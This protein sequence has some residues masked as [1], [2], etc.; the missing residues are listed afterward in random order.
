[1]A[2]NKSKLLIFGILVII[3]CLL[4]GCA[5]QVDQG[6]LSG[7]SSHQTINWQNSLEEAVKVASIEKKPIMI[8]FYGVSSK[9]IDERLFSDPEIIKLSQRFVC[10]KVG[11]EWAEL[12]KQYKVIEFPTIVF[13]DRLGRE[14][15]RIVGYK[16]KPSFIS[17]LNDA[18]ATV[19]VEYDVNV[20]QGR[21]P[22]AEVICKFNN[23]RFESLTVY[24]R[25]RHDDIDILS[26]QGSD[27][28]PAIKKV[29]SATWEIRFGSRSKRDLSIK[30]KV[31]LNVLSTMDFEPAYISY[32]GGRY[33]ILD[34]H[35][36]FLDSPDIIATEKVT[37]NLKLPDG[38]SAL[39]P[40]EDVGNFS[41]IADRIEEVVDAVFCIGNFRYSKRQ[42]NDKEIY[43][44]FCGPEGYNFD[45]NSKG[46]LALH[47]FRDYI[48]RFGDYPF[49]KYLAIF[50]HRTPDGKYI[51]GTAHGL[52]FAGPVEMSN[53]NMLQFMA[54]EIFH[55]W[56]GGI[57]LQRSEYEVWFKEGFTQYYGYLTPYRVGF[58]DKSSFVQFLKRDYDEYIRKHESG[59]D[60]AL[61]RVKEGLARQE[62]YRQG[63]SNNLWMMYNKGAL[64]ASLLDDE[65]KEKT[66]GQRSIDDLMR[67]MFTE[68]KDKRY[69][70]DDILNA[71]NKITGH[72]FT[73]FFVDFIY[74]K[75]KLPPTKKL[76]NYDL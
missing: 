67:Y 4:T 14:Y 50:A 32:L 6:A 69:S 5:I 15:T 43:V 8:V 37:V 18:S 54:H 23:V 20:I 26:C 65:I 27:E 25:E 63:R 61:T 71:V 68:F 47:I 3:S 29:Q 7:A 13:T 28:R 46:D 57:I 40:W 1:M 38:W 70:T 56:N 72:D 34:G 73:K 30:Y 41:Y 35:A 2:I 58:Y 75:A 19:Q 16:S 60:M 66:N 49:K 52:G 45:L 48:S 9:R 64:V 74:G 31:G 59:E 44:V 39:T 22:Q 76:E 51:H 36:L 33:G 55:V 21:E 17:L 10:L 11:A 12:I 42:L 24:L 62:H 53:I